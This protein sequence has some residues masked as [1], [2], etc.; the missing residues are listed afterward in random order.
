MNTRIG[1]ARMLRGVLAIVF[2]VLAIALPWAAAQALVILVGIYLVLNGVA[3]LWA[4][5]DEKVHLVEGV[6]GVLAGI[7]CIV[8][9]GAAAVAMV[10]VIAIW[11]I[12]TGVLQIAAALRWSSSGQG[13]ALLVAGGVLS[14]VLGMILLLL[15]DAGV[16]AWAWA[17]GIYAI[18]FGVS[19]VTMAVRMRRLATAGTA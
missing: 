10:W 8:Q 3:V 13:E 18:L 7:I 1:T 14:V 19:Q 9:P 15:P 17:I 5:P 2:G 12:V 11:A 16:V 6:I 4:H